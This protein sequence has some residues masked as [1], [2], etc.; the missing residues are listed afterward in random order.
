MTSVI[1]VCIIEG[2]S[3]EHLP[4]PPIQFVSHEDNTKKG[5]SGENNKD[6]DD[7][8]LSN[9]FEL[10]EEP[11]VEQNKKFIEN[12]PWRIA[13][14][15]WRVAVYSNPSAPSVIEDRCE[16]DMEDDSVARSEIVVDEPL[17]GE[18]ALVAEVFWEII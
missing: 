8:G 17:D 15:W 5:P 13:V 12:F 7:S 6:E 4:L 2:P 10:T 16:A 14:D 18:H 11:S 1:Y 9:L 3:G